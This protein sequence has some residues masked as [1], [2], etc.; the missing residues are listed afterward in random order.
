MRTS[1]ECIQEMRSVDRS[2]SE[3]ACYVRNLTPRAIKL[4]IPFGLLEREPTMSEAEYHYIRANNRDRYGAPATS[5]GA[6][7]S[8]PQEPSGRANVKVPPTDA[9]AKAPDPDTNTGPDP[10]L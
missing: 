1:P 9:P 6:A 4:S 3:F 2:H 10:D 7:T 5:S 8:P